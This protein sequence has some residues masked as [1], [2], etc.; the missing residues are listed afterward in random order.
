MIFYNL[1]ITRIKKRLPLSLYILD[2]TVKRVL[3]TSLLHNTP[4]R[5]KTSYTCR[6]DMVHAHLRFDRNEKG[7]YTRKIFQKH[8]IDCKFFKQL[9]KYCIFFCTCLLTNNHID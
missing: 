3:Y 6:I 8:K 1:F 7:Y 2:I 5:Y 9:I 4:Y